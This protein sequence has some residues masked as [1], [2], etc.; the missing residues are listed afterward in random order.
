MFDTY[1]ITPASPT[2]HVHNET[3]PHD[4]ADAARLY[5]QLMDKAE[6]AVANAT[7]ERFGADNELTA[8]VIHR[9]YRAS[10]DEDV[11]RVLFRLN[12]ALYDLELKPDRRAIADGFYREV[13]IKLVDSILRQMDRRSQLG[14]NEVQK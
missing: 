12:G 3:K 10:T 9:E 8:V 5:G 1:R 13:A 2:V 7:V 4:P 6:K 14:K 11:A